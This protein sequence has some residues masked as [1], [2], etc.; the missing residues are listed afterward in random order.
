MI[1]QLQCQR[2]VTDIKEGAAHG[3]PAIGPRHNSA[4]PLIET[5]EARI[6]TGTE[7]TRYRY[8]LPRLIPPKAE[9]S[10]FTRWGVAGRANARLEIV[11]ELL[12]RRQASGLFV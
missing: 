8:H 9:L 11:H 1:D 12:P 10:N 5:F 6:S 7:P 2:Q 4:D 3:A